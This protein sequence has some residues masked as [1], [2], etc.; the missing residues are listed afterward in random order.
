[1]ERVLRAFAIVAAII[2]LMS[3]VAIVVIALPTVLFAPPFFLKL[4]TL[5]I[6][7]A[8]GSLAVLAASRDG[9]GKRLHLLVLMLAPNAWVV[10]AGSARPGPAPPATH[11]DVL[12][13]DGGG[14]FRLDSD[15]RSHAT[16]TGGDA[17]SRK[18]RVSYA[19]TYW[20]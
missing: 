1:M 8:Y 17:Q 2:T 6:L 3:S 16:L 19:M 7:N 5:F 18:V 15:R 12:R 4:G 11:S 9:D 10:I 13:S 14:Y 20:S